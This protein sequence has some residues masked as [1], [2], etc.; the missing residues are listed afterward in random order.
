M[1]SKPRKP[2]T[3]A[4]SE[5]LTAEPAELPERWS[6]QRKGE[7]VLRL[8]RGEP[9]DAVSRESQVPAHELESWKRV[10]LEQG[11]RGLKSRSDPEERELTLARAKIGELMM[12]L[13]LA[14]DLIEKRGFTDE[15]KKR[16]R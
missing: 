10:F 6:V 11:T 13:E 4:R 15:W 5:P 3:P 2:T 9:L 14:E 7:L 1:S 16:V 12:R 8:L